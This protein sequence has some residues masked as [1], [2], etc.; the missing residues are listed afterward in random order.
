MTSGNTYQENEMLLQKAQQ[1]DEEARAQLYEANVGLIYMVLE[2][3]KNSSYE[4]EDLYQVASI[5]LI[6]AIDKFDSSYKCAL[7]NL[8]GA[9][10]NRGGKKN[11]CAMTGW[12]RCSGASKKFTTGSA[13]L[14]TN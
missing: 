9:D 12:S 2:R 6:K 14:R 1:G 4:Y 8:C 7:F 10:D 11:S 3:F 13:G 5:G